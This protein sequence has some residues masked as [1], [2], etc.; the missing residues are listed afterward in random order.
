MHGVHEADARRFETGTETN[1]CNFCRHKLER[2][3]QR[4]QIDLG[5][6]VLVP[7]Y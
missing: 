4:S 2:P 3:E 1:T 7:D 6:G 5:R